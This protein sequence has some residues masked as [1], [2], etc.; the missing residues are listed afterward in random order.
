MSAADPVQN[1][2]ASATTAY[3]R[4]GHAAELPGLRQGQGQG[5]QLLELASRKE[6]EPERAALLPPLHGESGSRFLP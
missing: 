6:A 2:A 4:A 5:H 3:S 1:A